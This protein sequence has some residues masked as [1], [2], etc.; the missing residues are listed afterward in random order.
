MSASKT[1][2]ESEDLNRPGGRQSEG[3]ET[4][5]VRPTGFYR[6]IEFVRFGS[7]PGQIGR[8]PTRPGNRSVTSKSKSVGFSW[9]PTDL[10]AIFGSFSQGVASLVPLAGAEGE[11][12]NRIELGA[13][14]VEFRTDQSV[15][16]TSRTKY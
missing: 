14:R 11:I 2:S 6:L 15:G 12:P 10:R 7:L 9:D 13:K 1:S 5:A 8:R 4:H 16:V 3:Y